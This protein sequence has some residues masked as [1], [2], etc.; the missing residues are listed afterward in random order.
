MHGNDAIYRQIQ[1]SIMNEKKTIPDGVVI[2]E[3]Q[4][5]LRFAEE[6]CLKL[7]AAVTEVDA[8]LTIAR[9][10]LALSRNETSGFRIELASMEGELL[11]AKIRLAE[12]EAPARTAL[13]II[14]HEDTQ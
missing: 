14:S 7:A 1:E 9:D 11:A 12:I 3:L 6:R 5:R 10:A 2:G 8:D 4:A 13:N